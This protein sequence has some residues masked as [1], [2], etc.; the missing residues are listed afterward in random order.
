MLKN[1]FK[2]AWRNVTRNK[3]FSFINIF[4]LGLGMACS[5]LIFLWVQDENSYDKFNKNAGTVY[6][7]ISDVNDVPAAVVPVPMAAALKAQI[8]DVKAAT[9]VNA[10]KLVFSIGNQKYE[11][12][13]VLFVDSNFLQIFTYPLLQGDKRSALHQP[14]GILIT[15]DMAKKYFGNQQAVG[16]L[17]TLDNDIVSHSLVVTGVLKNIPKNSHLHFNMLLPMA[18]YEH[19]KDYD[20]SWG[21]FDVYTYVQMSGQFSATKQS[22]AQVEKAMGDIERRNDNN[23]LKGEFTMQPLTSIHL[24]SGHLLL[25]VAGQGN[26][27]YVTVFSLVAIFI[28]LIA[29]INFMNLSTALSSQRAKEVGLRKTIGALKYQ[30][31]IQ[32]IGEALLLSF[33]SLGFAI[34]LTYLL[35]PSFNALSSKSIS[36]NFFTLKMAAGLLSATVCTGL[37]AG[38]YP[39]FYLSKF[40]PVKVLKGLKVQAANGV[41]RNGLVV[42]QFSI[43]IALIVCTM[44]VYNQLQFIRN[45]DIGFNK[46]NLLYVQMPA[47]GDL[48]D[49]SRALKTA[50]GEHPEITGYTMIN[51]LPTD[52]TTGSTD[53]FWPGKPE[54][55][56]TIFP[57]LGIDENFINTFG[58]HVIS[59]RGFSDKFP[60]DVHNYLVNETALKMMNIPAPK[61]IGMQ[62]ELNG[63]TGRL[64]GIVKDFNFRT[65]HHTIE[66]I[67]IKYAKVANFLVIRTPA[68]NV[69][70]TVALTKNIFQKIYQNYP[71][72]Y[73]FVD[74]DI[75]RLYASEQEMGKLFDVFAILSVIVSCLGLFGLA[76]FTIQGRIKEIGIRK[77]LG[78]S[79]AGVV[80]ML[81]KDFLKPVAISLIIAFPVSWWAMHNWLQNFAYHITPGWGV[82]L[83]AGV[84]ALVIALATISYHAIKAALA[85]PVKSLRTE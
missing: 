4:G 55:D 17:L 48:M 37:M 85:N 61:A 43:A 54:N 8:P 2:T 18:V 33:I 38:S 80:N 64:I 44:V 71:F 16:K 72:N 84:A 53:V 13:N 58:V 1:Y 24:H 65:V 77:V 51:H 25:D 49:N 31:I 70:K 23:I 39:A 74:E 14:D 22:I 50:L 5:L 59:G 41:F 29:C 78:A 11:E 60:A 35:L 34:A 52:L 45:R 7:V 81:S 79:V 9:R 76:T 42:L 68:Q 19:R 75:A 57:H 15:E 28:L 6:R 32:F 30:L 82:F 36:L 3:A 83:L 69:A 40:Q 12:K 67:V 47:V 63:D 56:H 21:N 46:E 27:D 62:F 20:G 26:A 73:G 10:A 66:P